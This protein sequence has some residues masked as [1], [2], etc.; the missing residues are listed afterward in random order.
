MIKRR[1]TQNLLGAFG[2]R[3]VIPLVITTFARAGDVVESLRPNLINHYTFDNPQNGNVKSTVELDLGLDQVNI[4]LINGA[5]R[6]ADGAW[7]GSKYSIETGQKND[8]PNDDWKAGVMFPNSAES[9]LKGSRRVTGV[10][11]MGWFK[12]LG[13]P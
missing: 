2:I 4:N 3:I 7:S 6:V 9:M 10:T 12:P 13:A 11:I 1:K 5:P 8:K